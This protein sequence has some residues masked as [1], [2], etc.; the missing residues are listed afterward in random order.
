MC[1]HYTTCTSMLCC[2]DIPACTMVSNGGG[3][4]AVR[5][6]MEPN[7]GGYVV[8]GSGHALLCDSLG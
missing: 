7:G 1:S 5:A 2:T 4:V 8:C 3:K 6:V